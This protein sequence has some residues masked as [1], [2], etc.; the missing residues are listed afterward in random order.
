MH[1][2]NKEGRSA[3][4][5]PSILAG[6]QGFEP[7]LTDPESAVLP[8]DD[9]PSSHMLEPGRTP[10][11]VRVRHLS[12]PVTWQATPGSPVVGRHHRCRCDVS[13]RGSRDVIVANHC[14]Q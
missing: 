12:L 4:F 9:T 13:E 11:S 10:D 14:H 1:I 7:Q 6:V 3:I 2:N 8:L 5:P